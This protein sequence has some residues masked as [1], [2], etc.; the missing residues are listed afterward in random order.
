MILSNAGLGSNSAYSS[1]T[2][3]HQVVIK[4]PILQEN[5]CTNSSVSTDAHGMN[6]GVTF[7]NAKNQIDLKMEDLSG[8]KNDEEREYKLHKNNGEQTVEEQSTKS[9]NKS[10]ISSQNLATIYQA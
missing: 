9:Q 3:L 8:T 5:P 4:P 6:K 2:G 1:S 10:I 7:E